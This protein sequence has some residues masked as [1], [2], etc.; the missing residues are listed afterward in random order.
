[1][2]SAGDEIIE[3]V[4]IDNN[5][6]EPCMRRVMRENKLIHRATYAL[7]KDSN[8]YFYV[9]K[10][11]KQKITVQTLGPHSRRSSGCQESYEETNKREVEEE[12]G[13]P[14]ST[15]MTH[16]FDL[17]YED[18]RI[19]LGDCWRSHTMALCAYNS[20]RQ[21]SREDEHA[22]DSGPLRQRVRNSLQTALLSKR[23]REEVRRTIICLI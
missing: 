11:S 13:V 18:E 23:V 21:R 12:M 22:G 14:A 20:P 9:Q 5:V 10:R 16:M 19:V 6:L 2:K 4:D 1:M 8:N 17:Y 7:V 3:I 15:P